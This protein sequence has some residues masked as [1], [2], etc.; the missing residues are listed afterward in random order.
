MKL[1]TKQG[2]HLHTNPHFVV[3]YHAQQCYAEI[4]RTT[5][6][7]A[8][9]GE[10]TRAYMKCR[11]A[12]ASIPMSSCGIL[13]DFRDAPMSTDARLHRAL[14]EQGDALTK[15]FGRRAVLVATS[16]GAMQTRRV[17]RTYSSTLPEIF[18]EEVAARRYVSTRN[19]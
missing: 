6:P 16:V 3:R 10:A 17:S 2:A 9:P 14:V 1:D 11:A 12:I 13:L 15:P 4:I 8:S 5:Q 7:F 18:D 19:E